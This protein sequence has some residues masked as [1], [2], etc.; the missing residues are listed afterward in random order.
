MNNK[1]ELLSVKDVSKILQIS[2]SLAYR[3]VSQ[4][5]IKS[6]RFGRTVRVK[7]EEFEIFIQRKTTG[8]S[9]N[10]CIEVEH[11]SKSE[12]RINDHVEE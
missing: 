6:V 3:L 2:V 5:E 4:G 8:N 10:T 1:D 9:C 12:S 11:F 7:P